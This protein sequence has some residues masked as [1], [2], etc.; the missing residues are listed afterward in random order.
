MRKTK[1]ALY[2]MVKTKKNFCEE[3]FKELEIV[4]DNKYWIFHEFKPNQIIEIILSKVEFSHRSFKREETLFEEVFDDTQR[5]LMTS[6]C[7]YNNL[8]NEIIDNYNREK[9][10][11]EDKFDLQNSWHIREQL[12]D[13]LPKLDKIKDFNKAIDDILI[14]GNDDNL[15]IRSFYRKLLEKIKALPRHGIYNYDLLQ[16]LKQENIITQENEIFNE[17]FKKMKELEG[18]VSKLSFLKPST[19]LL[20][21]P[22]VNEEYNICDL[23][24]LI[25]N[26]ELDN[27]IDIIFYCNKQ[28]KCSSRIEAPAMVTILTTEINNLRIKLG[29]INQKDLFFKELK[30]ELERLIENTCLIYFLNNT[31]CINSVLNDALLSL[32][33]EFNR[34]SQAETWENFIQNLKQIIYKKQYSSE[35]IEIQTHHAR[36]KAYVEHNNINHKISIIPQ[37]IQEAYVAPIL[38][39]VEQIREYHKAVTTEVVKFERIKDELNTIMELDTNLDQRMNSTFL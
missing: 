8:E 23:Y 32:K 4:L 7:N 21:Q 26:Q 27:L 1:S 18:V 36:Y 19:H 35:M 13:L 28:K 25:Q 2:L 17:Y 15:N 34:F 5:L 14:Q 30:R 10:R 29:K 6:G 31:Q 38:K 11:L 39:E 3:R 22:D 33:D 16:Y 24:W 9:A 37:V 20:R 12:Q